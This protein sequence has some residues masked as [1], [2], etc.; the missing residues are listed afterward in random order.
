MNHF[1]FENV[2]CTASRNT[3]RLRRKPAEAKAFTL[4]EL[5]VVIAII[6]ILAALLLP[7]L[8]KAKERALRT[9]CMNNLHQ[10]GVALNIYAGQFGDKVPVLADANGNPVGAWCWDIPNPTIDVML[11]S[12]LTQKAL[13]CPSTA[14][15]FTDQQNWAGPGPTLWDFDPNHQFHIVGYSFAF[16]GPASKLSVTNQNHTLQPETIV[17]HILVVNITTGVADRVLIADVVISNGT[18]TPGYQHPENN[19]TDVAGGYVLH[20]LSAHLE[21]HTVPIGGFVGFKD[22]HVDWHFFQDETVRTGANTP[23]FWW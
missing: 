4:I 21:G 13:F 15:R 6:A 11:R 8:A 7:V 12:G 9:Q 20:H 5:L 18:A 19:Y 16:S 22:A 1:N 23:S 3:P 14:P 2:F 10:I 17:D